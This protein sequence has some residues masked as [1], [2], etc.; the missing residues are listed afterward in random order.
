[1][2]LL[3][4]KAGIAA[5]A[6]A[7]ELGISYKIAEISIGTQ[8]YT[9]SPNQTALRNEIQRKAITRGEIVGV[10]QLHFETVWDGPEAFKG[11]E[12]GYWLDDGTLF[13]VDS[14]NGEVIT[15]KQ[16]DTVVTE[17][18]ELNLAASTIDNITVE[19]LGTPSATEER[20]GIAKIANSE[21]VNEG[22]DDTAFITP[23]K[24]REA[25]KPL[26]LKPK[27]LHP[28]NLVIS[29]LPIATPPS[30]EWIL[31]ASASKAKFIEVEARIET[32]ELINIGMLIY[33]HDRLSG[34][35][36][37]PQ[38]RAHLFFTVPVVNGALYGVYHKFVVP[39]TTEEGDTPKRLSFATHSY[40]PHPSV[41]SKF[42]VII[43]YIWESDS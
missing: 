20:A 10:G 11:K 7:G 43:D 23:K 8:G 25:P 19:L 34:G 28:E 30:Q 38:P 27:R 5:S 26:V 31:P 12:L 29:M 18:F 15:Y 2:S 9:P 39:I 13:A 40:G 17:A 33:C 1:M 3:I 32:S 24:L 4:T 16:R 36:K 41:L 14:R 37:F 35:P 6:R 21:Q 22:E 42:E